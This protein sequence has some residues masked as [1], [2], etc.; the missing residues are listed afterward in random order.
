MKQANCYLVEIV[1]SNSYTNVREVMLKSGKYIDL[2]D[3]KFYFIGTME[4]LLENIDQDKIQK[5]QKLGI[6]YVS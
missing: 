3:G 4:E 1:S 5:I 6:G 2:D